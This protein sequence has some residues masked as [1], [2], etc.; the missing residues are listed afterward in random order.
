MNKIL[1]Y[2]LL[3]T[4]VMATYIT[5]N[6]YYTQIKIYEE[7]EIFKLDCIANAV[8][9]KISADEFKGLL[10]EY[11]SP[12]YADSVQSNMRYQKIYN[13]LNK[14]KI[15]TKV[16]SEMYTVVRDKGDEKLLVAVHTENNKWLNEYT[17]S[18]NV[19]DSFY[20]KGGM[21]GRFEKPEGTF[22]GAISVIKNAKN[23]AVGVLQVNESFDTFL[24]KARKQI[25]FNIL[26]SLFFVVILGTL[27]YFSVRSIL[28][29]QQAIAEERLAVEKLRT[30][31]FTNISHDLRTPLA[32]IH[33][34][35][36]TMLMKKDELKPEQLESYVTS[37]LAGTTKLKML[38]EELFD[39]AKLE[40]RERKLH[41][42]EFDVSELAFGVAHQFE[43]IVEEK[44]LKLEL[45]LDKNLPKAFADIALIDRVLQNLLDNAVKYSSENDKITLKTSLK[46]QKIH[47]CVTDTGEGISPE[48]MDKVFDRFHTGANSG[49]GSGIG[50]AFVKGVLD[51]HDSDYNIHSDLGKGT[52]FEFTLNTKN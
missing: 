27:M 28:R 45:Q 40:S 30:E 13:Q 6:G 52:T 24:N 18:P 16:P 14:A 8:A 2:T 9:Y 39:L 19:V 21:I 50:L 47:I 29:R 44:K 43:K 46:N 3:T 38:I 11:P 22:I 33:G 49:K 41:P 31:L 37:S 4:I 1:T 25:Y 35:L 48:D 12:S 34:Y 51:L 26:L 23:E 10:E 15:M 32:G 42:E 17:P 5:I 7:K 36:E 20:I